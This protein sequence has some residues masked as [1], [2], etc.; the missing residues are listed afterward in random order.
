[1][2]KRIPALGRNWIIQ[3][4]YPLKVSVAILRTREAL[5]NSEEYNGLC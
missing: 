2:L 1:M 4:S 3:G 5:L